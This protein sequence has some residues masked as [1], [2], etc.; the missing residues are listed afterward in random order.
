M[1]TLLLTKE[2]ID[3]WGI[4]RK[5]CIP[6]GSSLLEYEKHNNNYKNDYC[7]ILYKKLFLTNKKK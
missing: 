3:L 4:Y 6:V 2:N 5:K 1:R 7:E